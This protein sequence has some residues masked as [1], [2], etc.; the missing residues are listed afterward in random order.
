MGNRP[1]HPRARLV[2]NEACQGQACQDLA[3]GISPK[4][5]AVDPPEVCRRFRPKRDLAGEAGQRSP[6]RG[7]L[8]RWR[9][10]SIA[11]RAAARQLHYFG[12]LRQIG[13]DLFIGDSPTAGFDMGAGFEIDALERHA[14]AGPDIG[15]PAQHTQAVDEALP[16]RMAHALELVQGV[17]LL[18]RR[19]PSALDQAHRQA[20]HRK[21]MR[22]G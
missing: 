19:V 13:L 7:V 22:H 17:D 5:D 16:N 20:G 11:H 21:R 6:G 14:A 12:R 10:R 1:F 8:I 3:G 4:G 9:G 15:G 2:E 18:I